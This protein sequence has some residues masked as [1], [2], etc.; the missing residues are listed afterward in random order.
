[1]A[2]YVQKRFV[3]MFA[4]FSVALVVCLD[5]WRWID[6]LGTIRAIEA[7]RGQTVSEVRLALRATPL[8]QRILDVREFPDP[9]NPRIAVELRRVSSIGFL[10]SLLL[11]GRVVGDAEISGLLVLHLEDGRVACCL[12]SQ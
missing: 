8:A 4:L 11:P 12:L 10:A 3:V 6:N 9:G 5:V 2:C 7:F 1:M